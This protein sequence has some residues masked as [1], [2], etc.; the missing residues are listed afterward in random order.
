MHS[1]STL[2]GTSDRM[3]VLQKTRPC[4]LGLP[5]GSHFSALAIPYRIEMPSPCACA[6][7][8]SC[9]RVGNER[10]LDALPWSNAS[11]FQAARPK[12]WSVNGTAAGSYRS[13]AGLDF[14]KVT[15]AGHMVSLI[16]QLTCSCDTLL[17]ASTILAMFQQA[18]HASRP[19]RNWSCLLLPSPCTRQP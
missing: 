5:Q 3:L 4:S 11:D 7:V 8:P 10:W 1:Q 12:L 19:K 14:V 13:A 9:A 17:G 15:G 16:F 2:S 6:D 18:D